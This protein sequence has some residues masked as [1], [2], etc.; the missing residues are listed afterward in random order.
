MGRRSII[1]EVGVVVGGN[2]DLF[3]MVDL[4]ASFRGHV[5]RADLEGVIG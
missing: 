2:K 4:V 3:S 1:G 5:E